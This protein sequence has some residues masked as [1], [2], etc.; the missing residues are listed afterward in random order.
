MYGQYSRKQLVDA[1]HACRTGRISANAAAKAFGIPRATIGDYLRDHSDERSRSGRA[2]VVPL[3]I[4]NEVTKHVLQ[5]AEQGFGVTRQQLLYKVGRMCK[6]IGLKTPFSGGIPGKFWWEGFK[7]R[8]PEVTLRTPEA[9]STS[10][11]RCMNPV[12][13]GRYFIDLDK[14]LKENGIMEKPH[15]I[16]NADET[17]IQFC[18]RPVKVCARVGSRSVPGR[19]GTSCDSITLMC[20]I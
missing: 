20:G 19:V 12:V 9:L 1:L 10:R 11:A 13:V 4:E 17:G 6:D 16:W 8:H 14:L 18:H 3:H 2:P 7:Q 15:L 5:A